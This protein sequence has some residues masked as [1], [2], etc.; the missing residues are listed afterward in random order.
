MPWNVPLAD[1]PC[2]CNYVIADF[3]ITAELIFFFSN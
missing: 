3:D 2:R 1:G